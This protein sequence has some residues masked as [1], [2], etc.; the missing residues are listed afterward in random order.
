M[1]KADDRHSRSLLLRARRTRHSKKGTT[2]CAEEIPPSH[3][4]SCRRCST[5]PDQPAVVKDADPGSAFFAVE[6]ASRRHVV[7]RNLILLASLTK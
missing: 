4:R 1:E 5:A 2:H 7:S 6:C 3:A